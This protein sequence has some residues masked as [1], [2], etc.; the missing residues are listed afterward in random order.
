MVACEVVET[1]RTVAV[2]VVQGHHHRAVNDLNGK[3]HRLFGPFV[4]KSAVGIFLSV[5]GNY[6]KIKRICCLFVV[7]V[8]KKEGRE[9]RIVARIEEF[10]FVGQGDEIAA[11]FVK[12]AIDA[13]EIPKTVLRLVGLFRFVKQKSAIFAKRLEMTALRLMPTVH[14]IAHGFHLLGCGPVHNKE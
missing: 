5:V 7:F 13:S 2:S 10:D 14:L 11:G 1:E 6:K 12:A 4:P 3:R 8:H 9:T